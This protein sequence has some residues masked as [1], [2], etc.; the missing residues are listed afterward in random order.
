MC[1][2]YIR[3]PKSFRQELLPGSHAYIHTAA[4]FSNGVFQL[5]NLNYS[6]YI[7]AYFVKEMHKMAPGLLFNLTERFISQTR[8]K[9]SE[10]RLKE[11][12]RAIQTQRSSW[13][14]SET[15]QKQN[16][17]AKNKQTGRPKKGTNLKTP[18]KSEIGISQMYKDWLVQD[19][20]RHPY[21]TSWNGLNL[22]WKCHKDTFVVKYSFPLWQSPNAREGLQL[23]QQ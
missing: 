22:W 2:K 12:R 11:S 14:W 8:S 18:R 17:V 15:W 16:Q 23:S 4:C 20:C 21:R 3:K 1:M 10:F 9:T 19:I 6:L 7:Q 13:T 5:P